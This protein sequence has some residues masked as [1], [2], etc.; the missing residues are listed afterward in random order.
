MMAFRTIK[1]KNGFYHY[2]D[3]NHAWQTWKCENGHTFTENYYNT[4]WCGW[5]NQY[6]DKIFHEEEIN[7]N[8]RPMGFKFSREIRILNDS[9]IKNICK[10]LN[11]EKF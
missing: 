10:T 6:P 2:H 7:A 8:E 5:S 11:E 4:C 3:Q 1:D 9:H